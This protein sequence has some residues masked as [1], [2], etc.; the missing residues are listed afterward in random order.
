MNRLF[1]F[2]SKPISKAI[3]DILLIAGL[4]VTIFSSVND[5]GVASWGSFHCISSMTWYA[6]MIVHIWQ[7]W[8]LTKSF[9]KWKVMRRNIITSFTIIAFIML[10]ISVALFTFGTSHQLVSIHHA[11]ASPFQFVIIIHAIQKAKRFLHL[12]KKTS[13][14]IYPNVF[15]TRFWKNRSFLSDTI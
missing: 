2:L 12:F 9:T 7:H 5:L 10:T 6:L 14:S 3:V 1:S 4:F 15:E 11:I 13:K 8:R